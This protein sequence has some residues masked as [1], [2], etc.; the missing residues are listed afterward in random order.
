MGVVCGEPSWFSSAQRLISLRLLVTPT[1]QAD[2]GAVTAKWHAL[3]PRKPTEPIPLEKISLSCRLVLHSKWGNDKAMPEED[4]PGRPTAQTPEADPPAKTEADEAAMS[5][6]GASRLLSV[7]QTAETWQSSVNS[8][9]I[10]IDRA[11]RRL[12]TG[13]LGVLG[14]LWH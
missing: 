11:V 14:H 9:L 2:A 7:D 5:L 13:K 12:D 6:D 4:V 10:R 3:S 8:S 1:S